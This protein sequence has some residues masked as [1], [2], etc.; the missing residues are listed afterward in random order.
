M[1]SKPRRFI[2]F[3]P[4][5]VDLTDRLLLRG[6]ETVPLAPKAFDT[7]LALIENQG[8]VVSKDELMKLLWPDTFVEEGNLTQNVSLVRKALGEG[9]SE[10]RYIET[11]PKRGYRFCGDVTERVEEPPPRKWRWPLVAGLVLVLAAGG[12]AIWKSRPSPAVPGSAASELRT[13]AVLPLRALQREHADEGLEVGVADT[14][15]TKL[16][17]TRGLTVRPTNAILKYSGKEVDAAEAG[18]EQRVDAVLEGTLQRS[19]GRYRLNFRLIAARDGAALWADTL[20]VARADVFAVQDEVA[21]QVLTSLRLHLTKPEL[22]RLGKQTT[23]NPEAYKFYLQALP[24]WDRREGTD[25]SAIIG[26]LEQAL[27]EDP[28][29]ALAQALLA[30]TYVF[31]SKVI[32]P[33]NPLWIER[34]RR[35]LQRTEEIDPG[36]AEAHLVRS[37]MCG[38]WEEAIRELKMAQALNPSIGHSELGVVYARLGL[39]ERALHELNR[40]LEIDPGGDWT[41]THFLNGLADLGLYDEAIAV[42]PRLRGGRRVGPTWALL[43]KGRL[44]EAERLIEAQLAGNA[45][46]PY[47]LSKWA[48]LFALR[49]RFSE[50]E[51]WIQKIT[52]LQKR[53]VWGGIA[54]DFAF[55][56]ALQ[57]KSRQSVEWL[58]KAAEKGLPSYPLLLRNPHLNPI[59]KD[60][61]FIAFLSEM[62]TRWEGYQRD[63]P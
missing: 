63:A 49:G 46:A 27:K 5:R 28:K 57:G 53:G 55:I 56:Y 17:Q 54:H 7:L 61:A 6:E 48:L 44:D 45:N 58:R 26:L 40:G 38:S 2:E 15:I 34:G 60:P 22:A 19:T 11:I 42:Y 4:F 39:E 9:D 47:I 41:A 14:L 29:F 8:R 12:A 30:Y 43:A 50:A 20:D 36:L 21:R 62:K 24:Y 23:S 1:G 35:A 25:L 51:Q 32:D 37:Q 52:A 31:M 18:R 33:D 16:S 13:L 3:G 59:R 10:P